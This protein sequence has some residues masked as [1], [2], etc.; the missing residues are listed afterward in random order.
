ME[1]ISGWAEQIVVAV[2]VAT[3][4]EMI[5]PS[6]NNKKYIKAV[7]GIYVLFT[8]VSPIITKITGSNL[9]SLNFDYEKYM[10]QTDTYQTMSQTLA[11]N[12]D[13]N[14]GEIYQTNL[15]SDMKNKLLEKGYIASNIMV[16]TQIEDEE[17]YGKITKISLTIEKKEEET[18]EK[19]GNTI[20]SV[21]I[22]QIQSIQI[23]NTIPEE[24]E[25]KGSKQAVKAS[26]INEIK[27]Y[28][29]TVYE[30]NKKQIEINKKGG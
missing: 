15:K 7:I 9:D 29:S 4:I 11:T 5:L 19:Q 12:N 13:A 17:A 26:E 8:I 23:G 22:N 25:A 6:G 28:L 20:N 27:T 1:W 21:S 10:E 3:I 24:K 18:E 2:I 14:I 16:E 30:V